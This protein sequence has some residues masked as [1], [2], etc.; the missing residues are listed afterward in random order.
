MLAGGT[1]GPGEQF[2][3]L[4][5]EEAAAVQAG[6]ARNQNLDSLQQNAANEAAVPT[7]LKLP[8]MAAKGVIQGV[9]NIA[10]LGGIDTGTRPEE[11]PNVG[12]KAGHFTEGASQFTVGMI[13]GGQIL[14][15][16]EV[17]QGA[18][19][20]I[21]LARAAASGGIGEGLAFDD[22][23]ARLL[24][25]TEAHP[26]LEQ[27]IQEALAADPMDNHPWERLKNVLDGA[28]TGTA[29]ELL[30]MGIKGVKDIAVAKLAG[31]EPAAKKAAIELSEKMQAHEAKAAEPTVSADTASTPKGPDAYAEA[32]PATQPKPFSQ[33]AL[34]KI[35]DDLKKPDVPFNPEQDFVIRTDLVAGPDEM[36]QVL[37]TTANKLA[38]DIK[39]TSG[40]VQTWEQTEKIASDIAAD[41]GIDS[42]QLWGRIAELGKGADE[43]AALVLLARKQQN[44]I[45]SAIHKEA[46]RLDT[47]SV[48]DRTQINKLIQSLGWME[49]TL[50]PLRT[51][52]ARGTRQWG[53]VA[54]DLTSAQQIKA[55]VASG[56][57]VS[58]VIA[59]S[60]MAPFGKRLMSAYAE[61]F[62]GFLISGPWTQVANIAANTYNMLLRPTNKIIGGVM[63]AALGQGR[64][65]LKRSVD[66]AAELYGIAKSSTDIW[67]A[68]AKAFRTEESVLD[69]K[70]MKVDTPAFAISGQNFGY[71]KGS[72]MGLALDW[73]GKGIRFGYRTLTTADEAFS[74]L[75]YQGNVY[76]QSLRE[77]A[78]L[79]LPSKEAGE[80]MAKRMREAFDGT[81]KGLD[82]EGLRNARLSTF[83]EP[84][85]QGSVAADL[86]VFANK[87]PGFRAVS[88]FIKTPTNVTK[89]NFQ[90]A[91]VLQF[92]MDS[93]RQDVAA[94]GVRQAEAL[95]KIATGGLMALG[96][97]HAI[98]NWKT[99]GSGPTNP[100]E[101]KIWL[102][103]NTPN[104]ITVG[105]HTFDINRLPEPGATLFGIA[106][107]YNE[108]AA[109]MKDKDLET[110]GTA[111]TAAI[112]KNIESKTWI[113]GAADAIDAL[114]QPEDKLAYWMQNRIAQ[115][116]IPAAANQ[117]R[118]Q[119]DDTFREV[120]S[121]MDA[122]KNRTPGLSEDLPPR[123]NRLGGVIKA[124]E[125]S[126]PLDVVNP[127]VFDAK[128]PTHVQEELARLSTSF[129]MPSEV[130]GNVNLRKY[131]NASGQD[132]YDRLM[133]LHDT[134]RV[135]RYTL[136]ER[137][138]ADMS[139]DFYKKMKDTPDEY[140]SDKVK[141][142]QKTFGEYLKAH[143]D[144]VRSEFRA[145]AKAGKIPASMDLDKALNDDEWNKQMVPVKGPAALRPLLP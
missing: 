75:T 37:Q 61:A 132:A 95:G 113:K 134:K 127:F 92:F 55:L 73:L 38:G 90:Q 72:V 85:P 91:P 121:I 82:R 97:H 108:Q 10:K 96:I 87:H 43:Q 62:G 71:N 144:T 63:Q 106:V 78:N 7:A 27:P 111:I 14:K 53:I 31:G 18:G 66:G 5:P 58:A 33:D 3:N 124:N 40:G 105:K 47:G 59:A 41:M 138:D 56:G 84:L 77:A 51:A 101:R 128:V 35:V 24:Q 12:D 57:D 130:V 29:A 64:D 16:A 52:Q 50:T 9:N 122:I 145:E 83:R 125:P 143:M 68:V 117:W 107:Q 98:K 118:R 54:D 39:A 49:Q 28:V 115:S 17:L 60:H 4:T 48:T 131:K 137:L 102:M 74:Q 142:I 30:F 86:S 120:R 11:I 114:S 88:P 34:N 69:P 136:S 67:G 36:K 141:F 8:L 45:A 94:G 20:A 116:L 104:S 15:T 22:A 21:Q 23:S 81:G 139:K 46:Y 1:P 123:R 126:G 76:S 80:Y 25:F 133:E 19:K 44:A 89:Q 79:N 110:V 2:A 99:V 140:T 103:S 109:F 119:H 129:K 26:S 93:W 32:A 135:G 70:N 13:A 65:G 6:N 42:S 112:A 100:D